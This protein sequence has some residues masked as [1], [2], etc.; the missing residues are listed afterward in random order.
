MHRNITPFLAAAVLASGCRVPGGGDAQPE[1]SNV[2]WANLVYRCAGG[3]RF[4]VTVEEDTITLDLGDTLVVLPQVPAASGSRYEGDGYE[5]HGRGTTAMLRTP[6]ASWNECEGTI[7]DGPDDRAR[8]RGA[9]Y[10]ARGQEPGW[11][12]EVEERV[13][14]LFIGDYGEIRF[15][16]R[17]PDASVVDG[18]GAFSVRA[19]SRELRVEV[20]PV[21]C[22]DVMSGEPY[23]H[24]VRIVLD[25]REL[26][27]CGRPLEG[28]GAGG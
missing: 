19:A 28:E 9:T 1:I 5:F 26:D 16:A 8:L 12:L 7:A 25:G 11:A 4:A 18:R 27:G 17:A 14:V 10:I 13:G 21:A 2:P 15:V 22:Q 24:T 3:E 6:G 20:E 23:P